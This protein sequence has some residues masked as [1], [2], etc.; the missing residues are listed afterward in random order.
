MCVNNLG[1]HWLDHGS[2]TP[3]RQAIIWSSAEILLTGPLGTN[4]SEMSIEIHIFSLKKFHLKMPTAKWRPFSLGLNVFI[5]TAVLSSF[6][7][8]GSDHYRRQPEQHWRQ[9]P[10]PVLCWTHGIHGDQAL[11]L[12]EPYSWTLCVHSK[13][14]RWN[15]EIT[16]T[17]WSQSVWTGW[18]KNAIIEI[19]LESPELTIW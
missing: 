13:N 18:V 4:F 10:L 6:H 2:S 16:G 11:R 1:H 9:Y 12:W 5:Q 7:S 15:K 19:H 14:W 8:A 3:W 17:V